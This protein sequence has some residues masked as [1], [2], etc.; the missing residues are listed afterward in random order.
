[1]EGKVRTLVF[2]KIFGKIKRITLVGDMVT[3]A[4]SPNL[5][6]DPC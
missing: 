3:R 6:A 4:I 1:M 5:S 2:D